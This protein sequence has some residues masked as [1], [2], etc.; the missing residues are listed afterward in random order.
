MK[1]GESMPLLDNYLLDNYLID[2]AVGLSIPDTVSAGDVIVVGSF[3]S[4]STQSTAFTKVKEIKVNKTG[5][6]RVRFEMSS[7]AYGAEG[8]IYKNGIIV[9]TNRVISGSITQSFFEDIS[10][11]KDDLVQIYVKRTDP[12]VGSVTVRN[13][14]VS[15][16]LPDNNLIGSVIL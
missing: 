10:F 5:T 13:F 1:C 7:G 15:I 6:F 16:S 11:V 2:G 12:S 14:T 8:V 3:S 9:G 4:S